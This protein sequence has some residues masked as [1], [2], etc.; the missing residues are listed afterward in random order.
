MI[1]WGAR[2]EPRHPQPTWSGAL[3]LL[4]GAGMLFWFFLAFLVHLFAREEGKT[5]TSISWIA[6]A[7]CLL[8]ALDMLLALL[9][10]RTRG[11][12]TW[13]LSVPVLFLSAA[14]VLVLVYSWAVAHCLRDGHSG[15]LTRTWSGLPYE[16]NL[17]QMFEYT[18]P[19]GLIVLGAALAALAVAAAAA[20]ASLRRCLRE[21]VQSNGA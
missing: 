5:P 11:L 17:P 10:P 15:Q 21:P 14:Q 9:L 1:D 12:A 2:T 16:L 19:L 8:F 18:L 4:L 7:V 13:L 20:L 3:S 6:I